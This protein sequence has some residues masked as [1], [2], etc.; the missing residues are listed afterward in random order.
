ML[1]GPTV[2]DSAPFPYYRLRVTRSGK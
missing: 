1:L 2:S